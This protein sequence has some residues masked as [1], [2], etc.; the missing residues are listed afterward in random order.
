MEAI[1]RMYTGSGSKILM[2]GEIDS[3]LL[4]VICYAN[5]SEAMFSTERLKVSKYTWIKCLLETNSASSE[6][7][8][9][10]VPNSDFPGLRFFVYC[11][12]IIMWHSHLTDMEILE[13]KRFILKE[14]E[15]GSTFILS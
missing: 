13:T 1:C 3:N 6:E 2:N 7:P 4:Q 5:Q 8:T 10:V 9:N 14:F 15:L 11:I 12:C